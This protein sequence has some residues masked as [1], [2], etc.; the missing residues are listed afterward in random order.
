M[1]EK[2]FFEFNITE[3]KDNHFEEIKKFHK[4]YFDVDNIINTASDLK[5]TS[6]LKTLIANELSNPSADFVRLLAKSVYP[7]VI[8]AKVL[9]Q[10]T[11]LTKKSASQLLSDQITNRLKTALSKENEISN[12]PE[13][14]SSES[15]IKQEQESKVITTEEEVEGYMVVKSILRKYVGA[16]RIV[17]RDAQSYFAI[18]LDDN[19]RKTICRL[20]F[21]KKKQIGIFDEQK[22]ETK[23]ELNNI[24]E[25]FNYEEKLVNVVGFYDKQKDSP[26]A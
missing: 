24:D 8:T 11:I 23:F 13:T 12:E 26:Q 14:N 3:L 4:S 1:D 9:E 7:G 16:N 17:F 19:N 21:G 15:P 10:F 5:Y 22:N 2:P 18:L 6:E 20:Y 25:I